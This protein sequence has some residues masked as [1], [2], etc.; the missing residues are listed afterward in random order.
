MILAYNCSGLLCIWEDDCQEPIFVWTYSVFEDYTGDAV[1]PSMYKFMA[2]YVRINFLDIDYDGISYTP[3]GVEEDAF[4]H[5]Y[6]ISLNRR[7]ELHRKQMDDLGD[8]L[9]EEGQ[10]TG[11]FE[12][13]A[14]NQTTGPIYDYGDEI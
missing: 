7:I 14:E 13:G 1:T 3:S 9:H 10:W 6:E 2:E 5:Y 12:F 8:L 4:V 11:G